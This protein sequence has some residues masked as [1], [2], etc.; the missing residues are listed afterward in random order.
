MADLLMAKEDSRN[1]VT[2]KPFSPLAQPPLPHS[3]CQPSPLDLKRA[4][5]KA[6]LA[7]RIDSSL[8]S[9][10]AIEHGSQAISAR[11]LS[12]ID[13]EVVQH[14]SVFLPMVHRGEINTWRFIQLMQEANPGAKECVPVVVGDRLLHAL[15]P[16]N[17]MEEG[18]LAASALG[19]LEPT[20]PQWVENKALDA[21]IIPLL[22]FDSQ[23][24]RLGYGGGYYDRLLEECSPDC[25]LIGVAMDFAHCETL[26]V[27]AHDRPLHHCVTPTKTWRFI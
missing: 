1:L 10:S 21:L 18:A 3:S 12:T 7:K 11:L 16:E 22:A 13:W 24:Y 19:V 8:E 15:L 14:Y 6:M 26:P 9:P 2:P 27:E 4:L 23:G 20:N 25:V 5:R 17:P